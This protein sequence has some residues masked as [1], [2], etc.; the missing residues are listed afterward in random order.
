LATRLMNSKQYRH[1]S[2][3]S[4]EQ[5]R[6]TTLKDSKDFELLERTFC[7]RWIKG[8]TI[9]DFSQQY[10]AQC[11]IRTKVSLWKAICNV[12]LICVEVTVRAYQ[13]E[14]LSVEVRDSP[15]NFLNQLRRSLPMR[16][17][18]DDCLLAKTCL[19]H[20]TP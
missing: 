20:L 12:D 13:E 4:M 2:Q 10:E 18:P 9:L 16:P 7:L 11:S 3:F 15:T 14:W 5:L 1:D 6:R 19:I 17:L 8:V